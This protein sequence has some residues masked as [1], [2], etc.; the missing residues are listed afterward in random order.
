MS[1]TAPPWQ[2]EWLTLPDMVTGAAAALAHADVL[3]RTLVVDADRMRANLDASQGLFL[4]EAASFALAEH[5]PRA[6]AQQLVK[7]AV[8]TR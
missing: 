4:A 1:G 6:E 5:M 2:L 3:L 7:S 8:A